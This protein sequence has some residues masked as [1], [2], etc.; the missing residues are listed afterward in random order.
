MKQN[1]LIVALA[2]A[3]FTSI[4]THAQMRE[5]GDIELV[6]Y[7]AYS[8][9]FFN[10]DNADF[11]D[12]RTSVSFGVKGDY[13]FNDRWSIRS[14]VA[15]DAMGASF[16][17]GPDVELNYIS[18]PVNANW[19]F[20]STR[21]WNLNFGLTPSFLT[22]AEVQSVDI[23]EEVSSFSLGISYGIGYKIEISEA[24]SIMIDLQGNLGISNINDIPGSDIN[25]TNAFS[26]L[27]LGGVFRI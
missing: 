20:G 11:Y 14:G 5:S 23:A 9:A 25:Q 18:V 19:H 15:F 6:P 8:S 4:S 10:G 24:F 3:A 12:Y 7:I 1:L 13:Y 2:I 17:N 26:Y 27:G 22:S 21:K 16:N